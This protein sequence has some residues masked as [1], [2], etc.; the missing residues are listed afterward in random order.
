[1]LMRVWG[2]GALCSKLGVQGFGLRLYGTEFSP[3]SPEPYTW[4]RV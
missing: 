2:L 4:L 1:M 3:D